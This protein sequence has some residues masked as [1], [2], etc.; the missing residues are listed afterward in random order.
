[1][2]SA[3]LWMAFQPVVGP[4]GEIVAALDAGFAGV[5]GAA[6]CAK[7]RALKTKADTSTRENVGMKVSRLR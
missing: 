2:T 5:V 3:E 4:F 1:M 6:V 7:E